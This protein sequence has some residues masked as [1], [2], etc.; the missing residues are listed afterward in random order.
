MVKSN[1]WT[2]ELVGAS[3]GE[4]LLVVGNSAHD[5]VVAG[6]NFDDCTDEG[7]VQVADTREMKDAN[8]MTASAVP[9]RKLHPYPQAMKYHKLQSWLRR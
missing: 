3:N 1:E 9:S 4:V 8:D 7:I 6:D 2:Q 5:N